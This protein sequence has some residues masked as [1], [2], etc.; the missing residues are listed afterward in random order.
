MEYYSAVKKNGLLIHTEHMV[1]W[2]KT[3]SKDYVLYDLI[4]MTV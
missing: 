2:K 4:Y 3:D 1:S